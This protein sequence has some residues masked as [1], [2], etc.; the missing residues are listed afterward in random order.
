M[1]ADKVKNKMQIF[2]AVDLFLSADIGVH[3]RFQNP[4]PNN[5]K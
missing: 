3:R 4:S 1:S 2:L 5:P